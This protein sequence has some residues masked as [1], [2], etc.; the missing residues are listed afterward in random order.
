MERIYKGKKIFFVVN[1]DKERSYEVDI[2]LNGEGRIEE[3]DLINGEIRDVLSIETEGYQHIRTKFSPAETKLYIMYPG[4]FGKLKKPK[5][6]VKE[7]YMHPTF[8]IERKD[9]NILTLDFCKYKID[10]NWSEEIPIWLAQRE[11][12]E[13]LGMVNI[14]LNRGLQRWKWINIPHPKDNTPVELLIS[15]KVKDI[16]NKLFLLTENSKD[17]LK[18]Y[19]NDQEIPLR[20]EGYFLDKSFRKVPLSN[21]VLGE[22]ILHIILSYKNSTELEDFYLIGDFGVSPEREIIK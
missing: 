1:N 16:P 22:N 12:R 9:P 4:E 14:D 5:K 11:I 6:F 7:I 19:L 18:I 3:W 20:D 2:Y 13:K 8:E 17:I 15:F 21:I 10:F